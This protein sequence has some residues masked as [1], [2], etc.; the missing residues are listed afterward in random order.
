MNFIQQFLSEAISIIQKIDVYAIEHVVNLLAETR[1]H[2][3]RLFILG[4]GGSAANVSVGASKLGL[5]T[6]IYTIIGNDMKGMDIISVFKKNNVNSAFLKTD[7][8]PTNQSAIISYE[9][10]RTIFSYHQEREY[11]L[12]LI[13]I[14]QD[15]LFLGST[16]EHVSNLY[17]EIIS[18]DLRS[19]GKKLFYNPGTRELKYA[20]DDVLK[21]LPAVDYFISNIEEACL[22]INLGLKREQIEINDIM[23]MILDLGAKNVLLTDGDKG[24]YVYDG[25]KNHHFEALKVKMLEKTGAGDAFTSGF[26]GGISVGLD[27]DQAAQWGNLN[28]GNAI[29]KYGAQNGLLTLDEIVGLSGLKK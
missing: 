4:V 15:Y 12:K 28:S 22:T 27:I 20:R 23:K 1:A 26:I 16:G 25:Y 8:Y 7:A 21:I 24:V 18:A 13:D 2:Q 11:S 9:K 5:Q 10:D 14:F 19:K 17:D 6:Y 29:Q 3:G